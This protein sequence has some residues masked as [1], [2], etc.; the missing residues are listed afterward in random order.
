[1]EHI[2]NNAHWETK[3]EGRNSSKLPTLHHGTRHCRSTFGCQA[4]ILGV[5]SVLRES[6]ASGDIS[7]HGQDRMDSLLKIHS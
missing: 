2:M 1:M 5:H 7:F 6:L 3:R 4:G